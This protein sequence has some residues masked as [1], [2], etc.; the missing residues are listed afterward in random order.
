HDEL[1]FFRAEQS[2]SAQGSKSV[3]RARRDVQADG[4]VTGFCQSEHVVPRAASRDEGSAISA[5]GAS[6]G[7]F[8]EQTCKHNAETWRG[9]PSVPG[10]LPRCPMLF[11]SFVAHFTT[12][13]ALFLR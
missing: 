9:L 10:S 7:R 13:S 11:P 4:A 5:L 8:V 6:L 1:G 12:C 2:L 3:V